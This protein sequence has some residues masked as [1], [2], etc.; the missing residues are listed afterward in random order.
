MTRFLIMAREAEAA[1]PGAIR[2]TVTSLIFRVPGTVP[3]ALYKA[4]GGFATNGI[5]M[6]KLES[7]QLAAPSPRRSS[8]LRSTVIEER[9]VRRWRGEPQF[10]SHVQV[11][12]SIPAIRC[13]S[14]RRRRPNEGS[15]RCGAGRGGR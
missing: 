13:A 4:L 12:A 10:S 3:A 2:P 1:T 14:R 8:V 9:H 15:R 6:T 5:N 11:R 7:H